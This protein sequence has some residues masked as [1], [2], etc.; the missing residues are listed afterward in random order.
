MVSLAV[1]TVTVLTGIMAP[2]RE[3]C[4]PPLGYQII[5]TRDTK[6]L[7]FPKNII[8]GRRKKLN[9]GT[10]QRG[11]LSL[12]KRFHI[13]PIALTTAMLDSLEPTQY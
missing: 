10:S 13:F 12:G 5:E 7:E 8:L 3:F 11:T 1:F 2:Y 6:K 4:S 9:L